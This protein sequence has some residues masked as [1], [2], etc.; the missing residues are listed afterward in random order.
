MH[1]YKQ[2]GADLEGGLVKHRGDVAQIDSRE[3]G[4]EHLALLVMLFSVGRQ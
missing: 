4:H 3:N 1:Q 2:A